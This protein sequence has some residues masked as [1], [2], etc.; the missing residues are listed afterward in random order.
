MKIY[1]PREFAKMVG[2]VVPTLQR[3]D[4]EG[5]LKAHRTPTNRRYYTHDQFLEYIGQKAADKKIIA[6]C[7]IS[8]KSGQSKDLKHQ[9][10]AVE[11][12]C[13]AAGKPLD[14]V[15]EDVGSG[16]NYKRKNFLVLMDQVE[17]GKISEIIV[18]HRDRLVRFGYEWFERFCD[19]HGC[20]ITVINNQ[21]LSPEE[22]VTKDLMIIIHCFSSRLY[23]LR[24]YKKRD[25]E[26]M[27]Q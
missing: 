10:E 11:A 5:R 27:C 24:R 23:G 6:Y 7:R 18:A 19:Q 21:S 17:Q 14:E 25:I 15:V 22:E 1:A 26:K 3:W 9:R 12:F 8:G 20:K 4:N 13:L 16:L 2:R